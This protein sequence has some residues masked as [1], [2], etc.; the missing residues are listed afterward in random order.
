MELKIT[1]YVD[2]EKLTEEKYECEY[3]HEKF[4]EEITYL[5]EKRN[6]IKVTI[7]KIKENVTIEK[8]QQTTNI[9]YARK[10]TNYSTQYGVMEFESSLVSLKKQERSKFVVFEIVY[11]LY[12][13]K[14]DKQQN[15]LR[16]QIKR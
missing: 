8:E 11:N 2:G 15:K 16:M 1:T 13:S 14:E 6:K 4:L 9:S 3:A 12:F 7:D 10:K 5:D